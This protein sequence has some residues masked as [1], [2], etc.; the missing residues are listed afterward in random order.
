[1][2]EEEK[3][4]IIE[5]YCSDYMKRLRKVCMPLIRNK[6]VAQAEYDDL[7]SDAQNVLL[8][9]VENYDIRKNDNFEKYLIS[10]IKKSYSEWTR[11]RMRE[12]RCN[13]ARDKEGKIL[14]DSEG[15]K[16]IHKSFP[17]DAELEDGKSQ[18]ELL[19]SDFNVE[20][21]YIERAEGLKF[22]KK[23]NRFLSCLSPLQKKIAVY[24]SQDYTP[25]EICKILHITNDHYKESLKRIINHKNTNQLL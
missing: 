8:E 24:I 21:M 22:S 14:Y 13:Y 5:A 7:L 19:Q 3:I 23:T 6:N 4:K 1:M 25:E 18:G 2:T 10:N 20:E 16:V 17:L 12:K 9:S 15:N 11:D